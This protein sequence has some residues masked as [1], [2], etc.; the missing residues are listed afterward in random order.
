MHGLHARTSCETQPSAQLLLATSWNYV[1]PA[2]LHEKPYRL[3]EDKQTKKKT[4][5]R[6]LVISLRRNS[7][8]PSTPLLYSLSGIQTDVT[9]AFNWQRDHMMTGQH[10][11]PGLWGRGVSFEFLGV[12]RYWKCQKTV[13]NCGR[14][15][16]VLLVIAK[17]Q[18]SDARTRA[19]EPR[20]AER[21]VVPRA[22]E[23]PREQRPAAIHMKTQ[24]SDM[25]VDFFEHTSVTWRS[26]DHV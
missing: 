19:A 9:A 10:F 16:Y 1:N 11:G 21:F 4:C 13:T 6:S 2:A 12:G 14:V 17:S 26:H 7:A 22:S 15:R 3:C 25:M 5:H 8:N 24:K 18:G 23:R 20:R